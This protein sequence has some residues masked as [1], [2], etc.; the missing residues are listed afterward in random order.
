MRVLL[1]GE[2]WVTHSL[3]IKGVDSFTTSSYTEGAGQLRA[4]LAASGIDAEYL[5][6]HLVPA[7]F[8]GS[9]GELAHYDAVILSDIGANS[10]LLSP[11]TFERSVV[12]PNR[13]DELGR[14][15][16]AGGGLLMIGGYLSFAG[17][18]GKA[19]YH[20]T[21]VEDALPV[22]IS[23]TDDRAEMPQGVVPAVASPGHPVL[24]GLPADW[25]ALLGYNRVTARPAATVVVSVG[26]DPLIA[27]G[28]Y[29][30]GRAAVFTSDCA[31][32]WGPP[33]FMD[34]PGYTPLWANLMTWLA[35]GAGS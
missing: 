13:I 34:W 33:G 4:A 14:Y 2:S 19:R 22:T 23:E 20:G 28:E 30:A 7:Q 32:H 17:I 8:P 6:G 1:C 31:P 26:D 3:H 27:C 25:P 18:E 10:L 12:A 21:A 9:A 24:A 29:R 16:A 11:D 15:V 5:P 35:G